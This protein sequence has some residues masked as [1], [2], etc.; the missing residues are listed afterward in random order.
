MEGHFCTT[1]PP[2]G[3]SPLDSSSPLIRER[4]T[5]INMIRETSCFPKGLLVSRVLS[6][7]FSFQVLQQEPRGRNSEPP[8][9]SWAQGAAVGKPSPSDPREMKRF[10]GLGG[11]PVSLAQTTEALR[12]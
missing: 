2:W 3:K 9:Q 1:C 6:L 7:T 11:Q 10:H 12:P 4:N 5:I 8:G